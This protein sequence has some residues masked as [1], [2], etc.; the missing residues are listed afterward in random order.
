M[1]YKFKRSPRSYQLKGLRKILEADNAF[2]LWF[3]PGVGKTKVAIDYMAILQM[4][5]FAM[6]TL[7]ICPIS[8]MGVWDEE[9]WKDHPS[10]DHQ[11]ITTLVGTRNE[12]ITDMKAVM[13][14]PGSNHV[15]IVNYDALMVRK[16]KTKQIHLIN[17]ILKWKPQYLI[18]DEMHY[19]KGP[20]THRSK[21]VKRIRDNARWIVGLTGTP[22]PKD[23]LDLF[24]QF[25]ILDDTIFGKSYAQFRD[26]YAH[27]NHVFPTKVDGWKNLKELSE[28]IAPISYRVKDTEVKDLPPLII[29]DIPILFGAKSKKIYTQMFKE[30]VAEL[31]EYECVTADMAAIKALKL[32]QIT[33]GF[34]MRTDLSMVNEKVKKTRVTFPVGT[35]KLDVCMD[36]V[37]KYKDGNK[38]LIGCR[39]RWEVEQ[40]SLRLKKG[41]IGH[42]VI[43]GGVPYQTR[44]DNK[45]A[46]NIDKK[47]RVIIFQVASA[48][49]MTLVSGNI[50]ILYSC[51]HKFD[52]YWQW[53]KRIHREGQLK[54]VYILR[55]SVKGTVDNIIYKDLEKK[56]RLTP[57]IIED[58]RPKF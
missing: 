7:I 13:G 40:I 50:G 22:I 39:F 30:L 24:S 14:R 25:R 20:N 49:A 35:E 42:V 6:N 38:I 57:H 56:G 45:T 23:Y 11:N 17:L 2:A 26:R 29:R 18:V 52:D 32:Q 21:A 51:T 8:A 44:E 55:L 31:D 5:Y 28:L 10:A 9:I 12:K 58:Y 43:M 47:C 54:P 41:G 4:K 33:G 27:M 16:T 19:T 36:L 3:D 34:I 1:K 53:L 37:R 48:T 46:F 15:V